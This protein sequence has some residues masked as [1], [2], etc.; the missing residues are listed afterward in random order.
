MEELTMDQEA[1]AA[2]VTANAEIKHKI[3]RRHRKAFRFWFLV[4]QMLEEAVVQDRSIEL[5]FQRALD[6]FLLQAF[7]SHQSLYLL[8]VVGHEEDAATIVRRLLEICFQV[9]YLNLVPEER[10][11]RAIAYLSDFWHNAPIKFKDEALPEAERKWWQDFYNLHKPQMKF[12]RGG[13]PAQQWYG[14][15][16]AQLATQINQK[17]TYDKDY[18]YLS[19]MAHCSTR[20][21]TV[22]QIGNQVQIKSD[23]LVTPILVF[24][25][26]YVLAVTGLWNAQFGLIPEETI[27]R[28]NE[29]AFDMDMK[30][31]GSSESL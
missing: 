30:P 16:L 13:N 28:L 31:A 10:N 25:S 15:T 14:C 24:G 20:A 23:R 6:L 2:G 11:D 21:I 17:E 19:Q 29:M 8:S 1:I 5:P 7:K 12:D 27:Q 22:T 18:R 9:G 26:R 3:L 4:A